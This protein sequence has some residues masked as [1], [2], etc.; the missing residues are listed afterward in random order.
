GVAIIW[1]VRVRLQGSAQVID[2]LLEERTGL[3]GFLQLEEQPAEVALSQAQPALVIRYCRELLRQVAEQLYGLLPFLARREAVIGERLQG[4]QAV[5]GIGQLAPVHGHERI[6]GRQL[7]AELKGL[8]ISS[9]R[10]DAARR[11]SG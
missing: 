9:R 4:S 8:F 5:V 2:A 10:A 1:L 6:I 7:E 3:V 11:L